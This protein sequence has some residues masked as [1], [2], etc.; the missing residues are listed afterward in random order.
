M[1]KIT[2]I[3]CLYIQGYEQVKDDLQPFYIGKS[4]NIKQRFQQHKAEINKAFKLG[5]DEWNRLVDEGYYDGRHKITKFVGYLFKNA[6]TPADL[7]YE[8]IE[9][10]DKKQLD[11]LERKWIELKKSEQLGFNQLS[12]IVKFHELIHRERNMNLNTT[13][14]MTNDFKE[15]FIYGKNNIK[16]FNLNYFVDYPQYR[17]NY[18]NFYRFV[19]LANKHFAKQ[20]TISPN[21]VELKDEVINDQNFALLTDIFNGLQKN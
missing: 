1:E 20:I 9:E 2:G 15:L 18:V 17:W 14:L 11:K 13:P 21:L 6:L 16:E 12:F 8:L 4:V 3:Y 10:C 5:Y 19:N 7:K